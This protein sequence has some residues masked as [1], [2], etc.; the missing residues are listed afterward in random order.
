MT[1][2]PP[3]FRKLSP[4]NSRVPFVASLAELPPRAGALGS[5]VIPALLLLLLHAGVGYSG[6]GDWEAPW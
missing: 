2:F 6:G 5:L 1:F 3:K 4:R